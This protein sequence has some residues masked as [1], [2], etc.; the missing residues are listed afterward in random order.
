MK[1]FISKILTLCL[2]CF[3]VGCEDDKNTTPPNGNEQPTPDP[4]PEVVYPVLEQ[5]GFAANDNVAILSS[6]VECS[7]ADNVVSFTTVIKTLK[8]VIPGVELIPTF[9]VEDGCEVFVGEQLQ[10]SGK[11]RQDFSGK[12]EYRVVDNQGNQSIYTVALTFDYKGIPIV[13]I[14]TDNGAAI[15]IKDKW[16]TATFAVMGG[17]EFENIE[18]IDIEIA[19]R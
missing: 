7:I 3:W 15:K 12:V 11:S 5:F 9:K 17:S 2:L 1:H 16:V 4:T 19:G 6:D 13:A 8:P 10:E 14:S 18:T